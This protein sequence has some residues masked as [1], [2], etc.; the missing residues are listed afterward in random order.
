LLLIR[1]EGKK[2]YK[3]KEERDGHG[4]GGKAESQQ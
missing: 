2:E 3:G 4:G 1:A